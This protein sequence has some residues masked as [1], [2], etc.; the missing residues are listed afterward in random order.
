MKEV[1]L[2]VDCALGEAAVTVRARWWLHCIT[3]SRDCD[4]RIV[5]PMGDQVNL[6]R[7][8]FWRFFL[9]YPLV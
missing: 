3:R 4:V 2:S 7:I 1:D 5:V 6:D 9:F 8:T